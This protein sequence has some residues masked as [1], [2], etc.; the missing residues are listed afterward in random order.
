MKKSLL[1]ARVK[2][3]AWRLSKAGT[4]TSLTICLLSSSSSARSALANPIISARAHLEIRLSKA[5]I[6]ISGVVKDETGATLPG[7]SVRLKGTTIATVTDINGKF[8]IA[9]P[10][11]QSILVFGYLG[12]VSKEMP[13]GKQKT[14]EVSLV[15]DAKLLNDVVV[16]GYGT[17]TKAEFTGSASRVSG[18]SLKDMPV[19]SFDQGLAGKATG[20]SIAQPNGVLNNPPVIRIRGV[21][22]ISL[23]SYPL[24]VVDGIPINT[25]NSAG[26]AQVAN[27]PLGDINPADIESV[28]ILKDAASTAIYGSRAAAGVILITT[29]SGKTGKAKVNYEAWAGVTN[30]VR[31]PELLNAEQFMLIKNEATLNSKLLSGNENNPAV[32]AASFFPS[33]HDDGS[34][35]NTDWLAEVYQTGVSQNHSI[36]F[37]GGSETTKYYF[38]TNYSNQEGLIRTNEFTRKAARFNLDHQLTSFIK[39]KANVNYN[40]SLNASPQTG[41]LE[42]NAFGLTSIARLATLSAPNVV[43]KF[44]DGTYNLSNSNTLGMGANTVSSNFYN[45]SAL[46]AYNNY[47]SENDRVIG[48]FVADVNLLKNLSYHLSYGMDRFKIENKAFEG[49]QHGLG[50][51]AGGRANNNSVL[52]DNWNLT[53]TLTYAGKI[54]EKNNLSLLAGYDIQKFNNSAWGAQRTGLADSFYEYYEGSFQNIEPGN[55]NFR[56]QKAF[57]S[58]FG[59]ISY[60]YDK[61]YFATI[62]YRRDGNSALGSGKK[63]GDFGGISGG[64]ALSAEDFYRQSSIADIMSSVKFRASWGKVGNGNI[65]NNFGSLSLYNSSLYGTVPT[66]AFS[67]GGNPNLGWE[68]SKQTNVGADLGFYNDRV[69]IDVTYY[70]NNVDGLILN[71][72]QSP[73]KGIPGNA[74]LQNIGAMYNRGIEFGISAQVI[75]KGDFSWNANFNYTYNKNEVTDLF[76]AGSEIVGTTATA[77]ETTNITRVGYPVGSLFGAVTDGVNPANGQRVFINAAGERVQ[78][79]QS[80]ASGQSRWTYLDGTTAAAINVND[81]QV[82]GNALPTFY[83]GFNNTFKY[84]NFDLGINFTYSGGNYIQNGTKGTWRDQRF[85]NNSTEVLNRWTSPGQVTDIPRVV[86]GDLLSNGSSFPISENVEKADFIRL[87]TA[88]LGYRFSPGIFGKTGISSMRIYGQ[89][90]NAFLITNY[91]GQDPDISVNGNNNTTPGVDKN[92]V[93][94]G[95][96]FTF[97]V[98]IGF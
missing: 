73:S 33:Y 27:N 53:H 45:P 14:F 4:L 94:Q 51:A 30:A 5:A 88:S 41:S 44:P 25:G 76:G 3:R 68:T 7:V 72:P 54:G 43:A 6:N 69:T 8:V 61:K 13:V 70:N 67:Q 22:S 42:G 95:R 23:S 55:A 74:I 90:Y 82:L 37:S 1:Y 28:N 20:V 77:S 78:Y 19:Q 75:N 52:I 12:Y 47:S 39:L 80:V 85:W 65:A 10:N 87:Q 34:M 57:A 98:N 26:N 96:T 86:L 63:Y 59:R 92:S 11:E 48:N 50:N 89:V 16:V 15:P 84:K 31:L 49:A 2:N 32:P 60:D 79:S 71:V 93:P 62:N 46:L 64:W 56:S 35:V 91:S 81:Y 18:E 38:S 66:F 21:N 97:G 58:I 83:G 24:I 9:V 36:N 40:N 17:Q 29:K